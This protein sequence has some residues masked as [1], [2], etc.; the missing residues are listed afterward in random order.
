MTNLCVPLTQKTTSQMLR[1]MRQLPAYVQLAEIRIDFMDEFDIEELTAHKDRPII[2]TNR[3]TREGGRWTGSEEERLQVLRDAA[4]LGAD[5]V[6]VEL[7]SVGSLG[8]I[9]AG[10][11]RIVSHHDFGGTPPE[12]EKIFG[13]VRATGADVVKVV[14]KATNLTESAAVLR[15]VQKHAEEVPTIALSMGEEGI[16]TRV[17]AA[18]YGAFLSF[19]SYQEGS[20]SAEG[21]IPYPQ[22]EGMYHFSRIDRHTKLY[23]VVANPV[24]HS[25]SPAIHNAAFAESGINAVYLPFKVHDVA[26]FLAAYEGFDLCG[27]SVTIPHKEAMVACMDEVDE[28]AARIG[29]V[30]TV[31]VRDGLRCGCNTDVAAALCALESAGQRAGL[32]PLAECEVLLVGAGG[33]GRAVAYGLAP[34]VARLVIANRTVERA[35]KLAAELG[36][37]YCSVPEAAETS[38]DILVNTSSVG[39]SP[40]TDC[41]PVPRSMLREGMVVFDAV[42][43]PIETR[44]L[45]EAKACGCV[46]ASGF[47]WFVSQAA[48]QFELWTGREAPRSVMEEVLRKKLEPS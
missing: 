45:R 23:G 37:Q 47:E 46:A 8:E 39:M 36:V 20:A 2:V 30:N 40:D 21:Q 3:P 27:L 6:D 14:V 48:A 38:P 19:A 25:M 16:P 29:A 11:R 9:A 4:R 44:L 17:L 42:Y 34:T 15:L 35:E 33:A 26:A 43:N 7:Q 18:K 13:S 31:A 12:L 32:P 1:A 41:S 10:A 28:T 24:A 22:M 5:F